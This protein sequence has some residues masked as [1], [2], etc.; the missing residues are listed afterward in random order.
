MATGGGSNR[1]TGLVSDPSALDEAVRRVGDRWSLLVI[2][3]LLDGPAR[4][5]ELADRLGSIAPNVLTKRLRTLEG[6][7][8]VRSEPYSTRPP[9]FRYELTDSGR[10]LGVAIAVLRSWGARQVGGEHRHHDR[11]G[12]ELEL[13]WWCPTCDRSVDDADAD[14]DVE[15]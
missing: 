11:C 14:E 13:R 8:L 15:A 12:T 1:Q 4:F 3:A 9:R 7:G 5:G 2:E 6:D 10:D